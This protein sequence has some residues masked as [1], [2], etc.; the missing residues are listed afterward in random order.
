[1]LVLKDKRERDLQVDAKRSSTAFKNVKGKRN[2]RVTCV[3]SGWY[4]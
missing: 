2:M 3:P 1:M 4:N